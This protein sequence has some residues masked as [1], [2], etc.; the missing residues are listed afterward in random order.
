MNIVEHAVEVKAVTPNI[1]LVIE[2]ACR[3]CYQSHNLTK[4]GSAERLF[5]QIVKQAHHT[6]VTEHGSI[7]VYITTDRATMA[8]ITRHRIGFSYSI[9]SQRYCNYSKG[10]FGNSVTFIKPLD[11]EEDTREYDVWV[12]AMTQAELHYFSLL[13][14]GTKP[15]SA[16]SV[17]PNSTKA[18]IYMTA[19]VASWRRFFQ[20]R[21]SGHAQEEIKYLSAIILARMLDAGVP[22][23]FFDDI[24]FDYTVK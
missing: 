4:E 8:Q 12:S 16:R 10:K 24:A 18:N 19:N 17:L 22:K 3:T 11:I 7:S 20:L 9:E 5:N 13:E 15:E 14:L 1:D 21:A 23:Y 6:S 2:E